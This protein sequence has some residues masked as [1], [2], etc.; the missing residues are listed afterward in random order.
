MAVGPV[1]TE[2]RNA[3]GGAVRETSRQQDADD[4]DAGSSAVDEVRE[5]VLAVPL[6]MSES[7][8]SHVFAYLV[9]GGAG[10]L[11]LVDAGVDDDENWTLLSAAA[12]ALGRDVADIGS[13]TVTHAHPDH[14][15]L[16]ARVR[17]ASGAV[18]RMHAEDARAMRSRASLLPADL[19]EPALDRWGVPVAR[20]DELRAPAS[21]PVSAGATVEVDEALAGGETIRAGRRSWRVLHTPGHTRGHVCVIDDEAGLVFTG[22]HVLPSVNP[23]I[24]LGGRVAGDDPLGDYLAS[25]EL[26]AALDDHEACPGHERRFRGL[27]DRCRELARHQG[28]RTEE[29]R[30]ALDEAPGASVWET[31][32]RIA[33]TGGWVGLRGGTLL[34]ALAQTAM[35]MPF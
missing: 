20:R 35:R 10:D 32:S 28:R 26:V 23:G 19:L 21:R 31:A 17:A 5:G 4:R 7:G 34:S 13:V 15:G 33:W 16:A 24:G 27:A 25:L 2:A 8:L 3:R 18:V 6:R 22:D 29:V 9:D 30:E 11:H 12:R 1:E 14:L